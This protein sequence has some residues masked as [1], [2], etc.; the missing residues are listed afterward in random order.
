MSPQAAQVESGFFMLSRRGMTRSVSR[1][2]M[3]QISEMLEELQS[4]REMLHVVITRRNAEEELVDLADLGTEM[5]LIKH[6]F[7][8]GIKAQRG[9]EL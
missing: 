3:E 9:V 6:P 1:G 2:P 8:A 4:K 5:R 7:Q